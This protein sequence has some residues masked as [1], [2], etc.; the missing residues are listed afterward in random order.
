[1]LA[2][3]AIGNRMLKEVTKAIS[4]GRQHIK[5][6]HTVYVLIANGGKIG[7]G[8]FY[9]GGTKYFSARYSA[10]R[11]NLEKKLAGGNFIMVP[12]YTG[13]DAISAK[14]LEQGLMTAFGTHI[15]LS[16][17]HISEPTRP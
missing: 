3:Y 11:S 16:L 12:V 1:M 14:S 15:L 7:S 6:K 13:L 2:T 5:G 4:E 9:V 8:A 10:H 17:I